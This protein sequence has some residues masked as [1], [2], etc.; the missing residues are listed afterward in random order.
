MKVIYFLILKLMYIIILTPTLVYSEP[1][2]VLEYRNNLNFEDSDN[3]FIS[4]KNFSLKH[5]VKKNETLTDIILKYYG[6]P[7]QAANTYFS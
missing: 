2:V 1:F 7:R 3:P 5:K 4:D 6:F